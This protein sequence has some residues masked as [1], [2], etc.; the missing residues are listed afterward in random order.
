MMN[1]NSFSRKN[2]LF[3]LEPGW[4]ELRP[5]PCLDVTAVTW[6]FLHKPGTAPASTGQLTLA[7]LIFWAK[8]SPFCLSVSLYSHSSIP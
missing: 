2:C 1:E 4:V 8:G 5:G 6:H 7:L 3:P